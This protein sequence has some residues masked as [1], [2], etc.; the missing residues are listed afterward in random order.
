MQRRQ[1]VSARSAAAVACSA[2]PVLASP[3][4]PLLVGLVEALFKLP[5]VFDSATK[6]V[7]SH[8]AY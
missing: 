5:P 7:R 4:N 8:V 2:P 1:S 3:P 6:K